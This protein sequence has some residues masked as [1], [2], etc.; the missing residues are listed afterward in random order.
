MSRS[1][2][3]HA[4]L[5]APCVH[6]QQ[7]EQRQGIGLYKS[8]CPSSTFLSLSH[9]TQ[10]SATQC[11]DS[12]PIETYTIPPPQNHLRLLIKYSSSSSYTSSI[13]INSC[14]VRIALHLHSAPSAPLQLETAHQLL[15]RLHSTRF[16]LRRFQHKRKASKRGGNGKKAYRLRQHGR[17]RL[18]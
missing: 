10:A 5:H 13:T 18:N 17:C 4:L 12:N 11:K 15:F 2:Y 6:R 16:A 7:G 8:S 1:D 14:L 9:P 3:F